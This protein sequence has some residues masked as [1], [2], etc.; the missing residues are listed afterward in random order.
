MSTDPL[1]QPLQ[2]KHLRLRNRIMSTSHACGLEEGGM[3]RERYQRYHEEKARGGIALTMFGGSSN[4]APDSPNVFRQLDVGVDAII[5][6]LQQFAA[7]VHGHGAAL[8]CQ[9]THLGRRGESYGGHRL[10]M[11]APSPIR[12]TLHRAFPREMDAHDIARVIDAYAQAAWRCKEGGLDGIETLTGGHLIGQFLSPR[13]NRRTDQ[14][15]G[16]LENRC[17]FGM[18]VHEAIRA[19]VG[20]DFLVGIRF[21]VDEGDD[22]GLGFDECLAIAE[23]FQAAGTIDF[24]NAIYGKMDTAIALAVDNMPGMASPIAP[25]LDKAGAFKR[26][27]RLPVFHAARIADLA[28]AR[29]AI[30]SGLLDMVAMTRAQIADPHLVAKLMRGEADRVRPCVGATHCMSPLR[31]TCLHNPSTGHED[32]LPHDIEPASERRRVVVV[33]GGPAGLEAARVAALRGHDVALLEAAERLGGQVRLAVQASW[34]RDLVGVVDWRA[35]ELDRLG[36]EVRLGCY[37]EPDTV[38]ALDPDVVVVATGGV[39]DLDWLDGAEHATSAWDALTASGG[40]GGRAIVWDG[41]GRHVGPTVAERLASAGRAVEL[42]CVDAQIGIEMSYA[43]QV[44]WRRRMRELGVVPR[45]DLRLAAL[46]RRGNVLVATFVDE[47]TGARTEMEADQVVVEQ[48]TLPADSLF[49][50]L[51]ATAAN[52]GVT[53]IDALLA[54]RS[55]PV[56]PAPGGFALYRVGDAQAS[57]NVHTAVLDA[58]RL[59][60]TL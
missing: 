25:W 13:T 34:R 39:P 30:Q 45:F 31:P 33:G 56:A 47:L 29:H 14:F 22:A 27:V 48:G 9:I 8:M 50:A 18:M 52:D 16:S 17:R 24:F 40:T 11:I 7:R 38:R 43:E 32:E 35:Q 20:D 42:V 53:D 44:I 1:L 41:T 49:Q 19:R 3:P 57:R 12:E 54:G 6:H 46:A 60:R 26:A 37:A 4:V 55:Q 59:C 51:R 36:V 21:V 58:L 2:L 23:R 10:P 5:P 15:G 28:T